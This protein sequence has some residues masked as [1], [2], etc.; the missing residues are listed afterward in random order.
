LN[1][2]HNIM[3]RY[4]LFAAAMPM[5]FCFKTDFESKTQA[6]DYLNNSN[7]W[8]A[9]TPVYTLDDRRG[10]LMIELQP[11]EGA[12]TYHFDLA[13]IEQPELKIGDVVSI[14]VGCKLDSCVTVRTRNRS[15]EQNELVLVMKS[16]FDDDDYTEKY[17]EK[18]GKIVDAIYYLSRFYR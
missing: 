15:F 18:G 12:Y 5:L 1:L 4:L 10:L 16:T 11:R 8:V 17:K 14:S 2:K 6:L 7:I 3:L 13:Q 9:G